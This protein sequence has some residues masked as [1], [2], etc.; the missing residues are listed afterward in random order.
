[1][2]S[3]KLIKSIIGEELFESLKKSLEKI[4]TSSIIDLS[5]MNAS[6]NI[7]PKALVAFLIRELKPMNSG[8]AKEIKLP[9]EEDAHMLVNKQA[10]DVYNGHIRV[11]GKIVH[12]FRFTAIPQLAAHIMSTFEMHDDSRMYH[13]EESG[14]NALQ[15]RMDSIES[16]L[17]SLQIQ[18]LENK[19]NDLM[20]IVANSPEEAKKSED[21]VDIEPLQQSEAPVIKKSAFSGEDIGK[22]KKANGLMPKMPTP[23]KA[24]STG[25][26]Q[27]GKTGLIGTK[28]TATDSKVTQHKQKNPYLKTLKMSLNKTEN[29]KCPDCGQPEVVSG[30]PIRCAC[31]QA[32]SE[33]KIQKSENGTVSVSFK[34]DWD[35]DAITTLY[36]SLMRKK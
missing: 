17:N 11:G 13:K 2:Q 8:A 1:M 12:E 36:Q 34:P 21:I 26:V 16:K 25:G 28:T 27:G 10:P 32:L 7:A 3:E 35:E 33:P 30:N 24:G 14:S 9:F 23:P 29:S 5:E 6:F 4:P 20:R 15:E 18:M 31:F 22:L 19:I